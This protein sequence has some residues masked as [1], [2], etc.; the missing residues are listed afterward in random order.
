MHLKIG[1]KSKDSKVGVRKHVG[2]K[3]CSV[4]AE[5][6]CDLNLSMTYDLVY[7]YRDFKLD[8]SSSKKKHKSH[9]K[10]KKRKLHDESRNDSQD[11]SES[12]TG[13]DDLEKNDVVDSSTQKLSDRSSP[14]KQVDKSPRKQETPVTKKYH[15][16]SQNVSD[17][18]A[19][20][21]SDNLVTQPVLKYKV[22]ENFACSSEATKSLLNAEVVQGKELWLIKAPSDFDMSR[23]SGQE[24]S[25]E[26]TSHL[27]TEDVVMDTFPVPGD[28]NGVSY[29]PIL[30]SKKAEK[31][32]VGILFCGQ[33][34]VTTS[35]EVPTL[36]KVKA[37]P[38]KHIATPKNLRPRYVPFGANVCAPS[39]S[40][41]QEKHKKSKKR[42]HSDDPREAEC[43]PMVI[44]G[45]SQRR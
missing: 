22:P 21:S 36:P 42:K 5:S 20:E 14:R 9:K 33:V 1:L 32:S 17:E 45:R 30:P 4:S 43:N 6:H 25:L 40:N 2:G 23:L 13:D 31:M 44:L 28:I 37:P 10:H 19:G 38:P 15:N 12:F 39:F 26:E 3:E 16:A 34:H 41:F 29:C 11:I 18:E 27:Q 8:K 35:V 24:I 7:E